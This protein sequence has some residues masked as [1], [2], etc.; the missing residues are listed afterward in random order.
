MRT[1]T[2]VLLGS[3]LL[4]TSLSAQDRPVQ[5]HRG[6]WGGFGIGGGVNLSDTFEDGSI[7]G[8]SGYGRIGGTLNQRVL[9][10]GESS[11]WLGSRDGVDYTRGN[12][13]LIM[14]F[15]PSPRGGLFLKG[16]VGVGYVTTSIS[17]STTIDGVFYTSS[18]SQSKGGF[19]ATAGLGFD[20]R[21]GRNI[22][23]VPEVDWFLQVVGS[24]NSAVF[25]ALPGT[26]NQIAFSLGLVW[27]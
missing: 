24:E 8:V 13:S 20:V 3:L 15:Y 26:N 10:A 16:G 22:Y 19:G 25:G 1:A 14:L 11:G 7:W 5:E 21:L 17:S 27:H 6:L 12:L 4:S 2:L 9:L 23:L 18:V